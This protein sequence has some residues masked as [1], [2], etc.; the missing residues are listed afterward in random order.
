MTSEDQAQAIELREWEHNNRRRT[1]QTR[2]QPHDAGYG[3][4]FCVQC[5][6]EMPAARREWGFKVCVACATKAEQ[7]GKR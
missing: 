3:P 6:A 1:E 4:E 7:R 5:D 2:F